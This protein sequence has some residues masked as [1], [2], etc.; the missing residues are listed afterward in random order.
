MFITDF[1]LKSAY[2]EGAKAAQGRASLQRNPF[3]DYWKRANWAKGYRAVVNGYSE[4]VSY[5]SANASIEL[6]NC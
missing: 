5:L 3:D 4:P 2:V 6:R 1:E